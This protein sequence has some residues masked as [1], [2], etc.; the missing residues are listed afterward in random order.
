[1]P[2]KKV[3]KKDS[4]LESRDNFA[5]NHNESILLWT[6]IGEMHILDRAKG[7]VLQDRDGRDQKENEGPRS[8]SPRASHEGRAEP[9]TKKAGARA[10]KA[11]KQGDLED[12]ESGEDGEDGGFTEHATKRPK[13]KKKGKKSEVFVKSGDSDDEGADEGKARAEGGDTAE[14]LDHG[15]EANIQYEVQY[16][17]AVGIEDDAI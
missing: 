4:E 11:T 14:H 3:I 15:K 17:Y 9:K 16:E 12:V 2:P 6:I 1:M 10:T 7:L 8:S 5:F 13:A